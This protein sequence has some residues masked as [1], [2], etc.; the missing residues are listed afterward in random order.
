M[1]VKNREV[2][3]VKK[4]E[5]RKRERDRKNTHRGTEKR[6]SVRRRRQR[7]LQSDRGVDLLISEGLCSHV[8]LFINR[9]K[10]GRTIKLHEVQGAILT[11]EL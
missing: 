2:R 4:E 5:T 6:G 10:Q 1:S 11:Q 8:P 7:D 9:L 3:K